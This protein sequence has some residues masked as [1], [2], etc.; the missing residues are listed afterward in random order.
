MHVAP[1]DRCDH[2]PP[3]RRYLEVSVIVER[4]QA[5]I[6]FNFNFRSSS[7]LATNTGREVIYDLDLL[8]FL[9]LT[10]F[11]PLLNDFFSDPS[12]H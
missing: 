4:P 1:Q 7:A 8:S 10:I 12:F 3:F 11:L 9:L 6:G 2:A 5:G